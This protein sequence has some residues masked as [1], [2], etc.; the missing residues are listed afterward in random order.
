[1]TD[2]RVQEICISCE[3]KEKF[4]PAALRT[5]HMVMGKRRT[6]GFV[7]ADG[8]RGIEKDLGFGIPCYSLLWSNAWL[9]VTTAHVSSVV[10]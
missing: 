1:V 2:Y 10:Y 7:I 4:S 6:G 8:S 9:Y 3:R 5:S